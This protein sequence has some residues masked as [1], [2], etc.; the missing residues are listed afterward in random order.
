MSQFSDEMQQCID[1]IQQNDRSIVSLAAGK[2]LSM[3]TEDSLAALYSM[4]D[5]L[6]KHPSV[7]WV[8]INGLAVRQVLDAAEYYENVLL[9]D[10]VKANG[11]L[12]EIALSHI[13]ALDTPVTIHILS[14]SL[15][16]K[17]SEQ[18]IRTKVSMLAELSSDA[19]LYRL[20]SI[21]R[22]NSYPT[23]Q[24]A[25]AKQMAFRYEPD[26]LLPL[27][28]GWFYSD[29]SDNKKDI[30]IPLLWCLIIRNEFEDFEDEVISALKYCLY[31]LPDLVAI[32]LRGLLTMNT[33]KSKAALQQWESETKQAE[34]QFFR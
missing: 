24:H 17:S 33:T 26:V 18:F 31:N 9:Q 25:V 19:D 22:Q 12:Q 20:A 16:Y 29:I 28:L 1:D 11:V 4:L 15:I 23:V 2:L 7:Y 21:M 13:T 6:Q 8:V 5:N 27:A 32:A 30:T 34:M 14:E 3:N 10:T